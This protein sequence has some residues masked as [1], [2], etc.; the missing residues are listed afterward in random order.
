MLVSKQAAHRRAG[1]EH[2]LHQ[3]ACSAAAHC[4]RPSSRAQAADVAAAAPSAAAAL[5]A[6]LLRTAHGDVHAEGSSERDAGEAGAKPSHAAAYHG[7]RMV[8][9]E[10]AGL[11]RALHAHDRAHH[12]RPAVSAHVQ[13]TDHA[14]V[15]RSA[16]DPSEAAAANGGRHR[17]MGRV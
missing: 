16:A 6:R 2:R 13:R 17:A 12:A 14:H 8:D 7:L 3:Y 4:A 9:T 5:R 10:A 11:G 1:H 15:W